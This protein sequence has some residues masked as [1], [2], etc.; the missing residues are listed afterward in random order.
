[1]RRTDADRVRQYRQ[2]RTDEQRRER[3]DAQAA[4]QRERRA[5]LTD[6]QRRV[7]QDATARAV[8][9]CRGGVTPLWNALQLPVGAREDQL[10]YDLHA[11]SYTHLTLPTNREV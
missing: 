1:M 3:Q 10:L 11:V 5:N 6:D 2:R 7:E 9:A 8:R 4:A